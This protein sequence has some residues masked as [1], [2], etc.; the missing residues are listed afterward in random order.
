MSEEAFAQ[1]HP[2]VQHHVIS[3]LRWP[4]LRPLQ[5]A[6]V[7]PVLADSDA[8]LLAPTAG[9]KTEAAVFPLLTRMARQNWEGTSVLYLCPLKALLN[10]LEP[11][12][13][14]YANWLGRSAQLWHGDVTQSRRDKIQR[15][16]PDIL[17]TTPESLEAMLVSTKV[18]ARWFFRSLRAVVVDEVHAFAGDDRGWHLLAVLERLS[19]I[20]GRPLQRIGLSATVGNPE[21]LLRWLQ[22][23]ES[24]RRAQVVAPTAENAVVDVDITLDHVGTIENA[25]KIIS[26]LH[27]GEK[28][29]V[30]VDSRRRA[31][32]LG[33]ALRAFGVTTFLSH[34]SLSA[35]ERRRSED[36]FSDAKDCVI[37]ATSTLELGIDVGDLDRV[38]QIDAPRTVASFLQRLGR[39]GRRPDTTRNCLFLCLEQ[40][41]VLH[42]AGLLLRWA[43]DWVEP[44]SPP[45]A[46]RHI[47]AQQLLALALQEHTIGPRSWREW[48]G[49]LDLFGPDAEAILHHLI[50]AGYFALDG[51]LA[52]IGPEAER[53][54]GRRYFSDLTAVF[55]APPQF[56]VL[57]GREEIGT[58]TDEL[59]VTETE[60]P[61]V[62]LLG[63]RS[64][65]VT[66]IDWT[67]RRCFVELTD[68]P[69][70]ARWGASGGGLSFE[71]SRGVR[72]VLLGTDPGGVTL[73]GRA[74]RALAEQRENHSSHVSAGGT[75][76]TLRGGTAF[77][78][79]WAG[80]A[81]NRTLQA[82][83][84]QVAPTPPPAGG[85]PGGGGGGPPP[86]VLRAD[87]QRPRSGAHTRRTD[88]KG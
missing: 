15:T 5:E 70:R 16:E 18:D 39:T 42:A 24:H 63:G 34:S 78:W 23:A 22:G 51:E 45:V 35:V 60:G 57:A 40:S 67:R 1:L 59:L 68:L 33:S 14:G 13:D 55:S 82:S 27:G 74:Q 84:R 62:L 25:A 66:H 2:I 69:G 17:M 44:I 77:W 75:V 3:T 36:A 56:T 30:F 43:Q 4:G 41:S 6:A 37:V 26:S 61:R 11:R 32:E 47:V 83:L 72:E 58:V 9:G 48:W 80:T 21:Q 86:C 50:D 7:Q 65:L 38:I 52:F 53:R 64:W 49:D 46:P 81:A 28:R 10:N 71:I 85:P 79:T 29:L 20:A 12:L 8:L 31:E 88:Q 76:I 73:T 19:R 54:F 87:P